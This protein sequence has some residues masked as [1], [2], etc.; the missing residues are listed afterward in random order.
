MSPD[1]IG[2]VSRPFALHRVTPQGVQASVD[3]TLEERSALAADLRLPAIHALRGTFKVAGTADRVRVTGR[4]EAEIE[5]VCVVTLDA[6]ASR[7]DEE[8]ELEFEAPQRRR[9]PAVDAVEVELDH[10]P[11]EELAGDT[12]DLGAIAAEFLA[13]GLDAYPRKPGVA[14]EPPEAN[15]ASEGPFARLAA[16]R[17][18]D[19]A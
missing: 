17:P 19:E 5:Q 16:L 1:S 3:A 6:F 8:V 18:K 10:D 4:V 11:P 15:D 12:V 2:P 14:F 7:V 13:L 9:R